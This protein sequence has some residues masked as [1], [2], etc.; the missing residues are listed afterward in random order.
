MRPPALVPARRHPIGSTRRVEV[1]SVDSASVYQIVLC[2]VAD[3]RV[4]D[5]ESFL[6]LGQLGEFD[7]EVGDK[8]VITREAGGPLGSGR[9]TL[10]ITDRKGGVL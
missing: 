8:G 5:R 3:G 4:I 1:L 10:A 2:G 7:C 6:V 9:W